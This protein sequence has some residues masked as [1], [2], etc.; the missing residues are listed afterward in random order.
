M[1]PTIRLLA[2]GLLAVGLAE[3]TT[4]QAAN[5][6]F[7]GSW[8]IKSFGNERTGGTGDSAYYSAFAIPQGIQCNPFQ[9]RCPFASTPTD[10]YGNFAPLGGSQKQAI[11][12]APWANFG[13]MGTTMRPANGQTLTNGA[14]S[15]RPIPPLYRNPGFFTPGGAR[16]A[17]S[18]TATSTD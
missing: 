18:C 17:T 16:N 13:G 9:P 5:Q 4:A 14:K 1:L 8:V 12:C 11:H 7:Q 3:G 10:G 15:K 6:L 2:V